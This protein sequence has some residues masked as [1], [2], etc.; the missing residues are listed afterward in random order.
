MTIREINQYINKIS[1]KNFAL[2][3]K[4]KDME[5]QEFLEQLANV[6][7]EL[8]DNEIADFMEKLTA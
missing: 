6:K 8:I 3:E 4:M 7:S 5:P 2:A 1:E